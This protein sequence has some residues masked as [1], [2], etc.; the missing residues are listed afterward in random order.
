MPLL[1][2][3]GS[4]ARGKGTV[5]SPH[6]LDEFLAKIDDTH[7]RPFTDDAL[8]VSCDGCGSM[9]VFQPSEVA[10]SCPF[11]G[12]TMVTQPKAADPLIAPDGVLPAKVP[13]LAALHSGIGYLL[14]HIRLDL[15]NE[16]KRTG[17][18]EAQL[19]KRP[20]KSFDCRMLTAG[21]GAFRAVAGCLVS[22]AT[23]ALSLP[24]E[25]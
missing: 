9:V 7:L 17:I 11:C 10:A 25:A 21:P 22:P 18:F 23:H 24:W 2:A 6:S 3:H 16:E 1:R 4:G 5:A 15:P 20:S 8:Q 13:I 14:L 19:A 12:A